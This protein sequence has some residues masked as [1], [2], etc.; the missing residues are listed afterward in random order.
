MEMLQQL[1]S[2]VCGVE[3]CTDSEYAKRKQPCL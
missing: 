3:G 1:Q 2:K